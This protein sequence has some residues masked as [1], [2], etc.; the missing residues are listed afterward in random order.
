MRSRFHGLT[1]LIWL[2]GPVFSFGLLNAAH[3]QLQAPSCWVSIPITGAIGPATLDLIERAEAQHASELVE[4]GCSKDQKGGVL[5]EINTPGGNL[6]T[7]RMIVERILASQVPFVCWVGPAGG[8]AG[9]AG[10]IILQACHVAGAEET[11]NIGAA[12]PISSSGEEMS[13]DLRAKLVND[14]T[15][16]VENLAELRGRNKSFARDIIEKA[17][18]SS[19]KEALGLKAIDYLAASSY[20]LLRKAAGREVQ[21][22]AT[23][24]QANLAD[25]TDAEPNSVD[26][27]KSKE[28][29]NEG[30]TSVKLAADFKVTA[31]E[32]GLRH[33]ALR[34]IAD[35]E[36][37]YLLF[38]GSLGLLYFEIT[39]P[40]TI[41]P[42]VLGAMGL[43]ASMIAFHKLNVSWG[44]FALL[45]LGVVFLVLEIFV[46]SFGVLGVAGLVSMGLG[47]LLLFD[48]VTTGYS[49]PLSMIL[50]PLFALGGIMLA[51]GIMI[52][53]LN[54][55]PRQVG[56]ESMT[57]AK[58]K[59]VG[60]EPAQSPDG[61]AP[62][63]LHR[64]RVDLGGELWHAHSGE[65]FE[66]GDAVRVV[67]VEG[68]RLQIARWEK[69]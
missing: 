49:L 54:R 15:S 31:L 18:S 40:G 69:V 68:L 36:F 62:A 16:W 57:G 35:P 51:L 25:T 46:T 43:V 20:E 60:V 28:N 53:R 37:S 1:T 59:I 38:M 12:T 2:T 32:P 13:K 42:G 11:T 45:I 30:L 61:V 64:Y 63:Q 10:A 3:A 7:T 26:G 66:V 41:V 27:T 23:G 9:S 19:A 44:G 8:H 67:A 33:T 48:P 4:D 6:Q 21:V 47:A 14:T 55:I 50:P 29:R 39:H 24:A 17:K 65:Q 5:L 56:K 52:A 22:A 58:A 34:W